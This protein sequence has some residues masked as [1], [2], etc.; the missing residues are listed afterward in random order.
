MK[1]KSDAAVISAKKH[2]LIYCAPVLQKLMQFIALKGTLKQPWDE[3]MMD[4][5]LHS[6]LSYIEST[7]DLSRLK[8]LVRLLL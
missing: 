3:S 2:S 8:S 1:A 4:I 5:C 7:Y 6:H